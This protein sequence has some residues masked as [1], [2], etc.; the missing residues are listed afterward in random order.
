MIFVMMME[1]RCIYKD[2][3]IIYYNYKEVQLAKFLKDEIIICFLNYF[4]VYIRVHIFLELQHVINNNKL[5]Y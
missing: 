2:T 5:R 3:Y 1:N 4:D